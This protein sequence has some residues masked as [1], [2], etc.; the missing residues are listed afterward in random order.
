MKIKVPQMF[1]SFMTYKNVGHH[2]FQ[3]VHILV[4]QKSML[5]GHYLFPK[6]SIIIAFSFVAVSY[7]YNN[8]QRHSRN[9]IHECQEHR[10]KFW[11]S[12]IL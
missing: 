5:R 10:C 11:P 2:I 8:F 3:Y 1:V 12:E 4:W 7:L 6:F 9:F